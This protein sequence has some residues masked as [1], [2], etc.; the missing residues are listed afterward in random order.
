MTII[1]EEMKRN[2]VVDM[3]MAPAVL[4]CTEIALVTRGIDDPERVVPVLLASAWNHHKEA[5]GANALASF[6]ARLRD[7]ADR[8]EAMERPH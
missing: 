8:I 5:H 3:E 4:F 6:V 2:T 1:T 7:W